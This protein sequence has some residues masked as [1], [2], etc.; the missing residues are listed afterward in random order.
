MVKQ[1]IVRYCRVFTVLPRHGRTD[2]EEGALTTPANGTLVQGMVQLVDWKLKVDRCGLPSC[3]YQEKSCSLFLE[4][5]QN[6]RTHPQFD[7]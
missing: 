1:M 3:W 2:E 4:S 5:V 6:L 7:P